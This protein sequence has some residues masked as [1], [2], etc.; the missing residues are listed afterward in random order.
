MR[1]LDDDT[2]DALTETFNLAL[3]HAALHFSELVKQEVVLSV[4]QVALIAPAELR[5]RL[6]AAVGLP[7]GAPLVR[8]AQ[9]FR[10]RRGDIRAQALLVFGEQDC[11]LMLARLLRQPA[12]GRLGDLERDALG[13]VG[14]V[15]LNACMNRLADVMD[16]PMTGSLPQIG[17]GPASRL[18]AAD[19]AADTPLLWAGMGLSLADQQTTGQLVFVMDDASLECAIRQ[20]RS[21]FGMAGEAA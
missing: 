2:R 9:Q 6:A 17:H 15:I 16:R 20:V 19:A 11:L 7:E 12:T 18:L 1:F 8:L 5:P 14:N 13:E 21:Y 3:G 4:P 10:S